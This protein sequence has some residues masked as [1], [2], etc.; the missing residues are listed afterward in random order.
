MSSAFTQVRDQTFGRPRGLLGRIGG[1]VMA[2]ANAATERHVVHVARLAPGETVLVVGPG[3]GIGLAAA[4][5]D[6]RTVIGV[7][8]SEEM[9][10]LSRTRCPAAELRLG[11]AART[12]QPDASVDVVVSVN[13]VQLWQDR[14]AAL[15]ELRRVLHAGGRLVLSAHQGKLGVPR[16][17]LAAEVAAAGFTDLQTWAWNPPGFGATAAELRAVAL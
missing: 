15:A 8:P 12:G 5:G 6:G 3:P 10:A 9:L 4:A 13:N 11:T 1:A 14:P 7:D 16:H 17:Q 2:R